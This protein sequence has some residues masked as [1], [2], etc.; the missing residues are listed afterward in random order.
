MSTPVFNEATGEIFGVVT[1]ELDLLARVIQA[2]GQL[3]Q[4]TAKIYVTDADGKAWVSD[5]PVAGIKV[6]PHQMDDK[7]GR[8]S[9]VEIFSNAEQDRILN[10]DE[11][12]IANRITLDPSNPQT[13][14]GLILELGD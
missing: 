8:L 5:D 14:I 7:S 9:S 1:L 11:G 13:T 6:M 3:E 12:W 2:V 10:Q 4:S